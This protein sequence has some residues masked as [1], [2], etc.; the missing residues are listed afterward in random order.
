MY[1][2]PL[3]NYSSDRI[4]TPHIQ[5][6]LQRSAENGSEEPVVGQPGD[7]GEQSLVVVPEGLS[8]AV[9]QTGELLKIMETR[10]Q[11]KV[12][13]VDQSRSKEAREDRVVK[14]AAC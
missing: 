14:E 11:S 7:R 8:E 6:I 12:E 1:K 10:E 4:K 5:T 9:Q 2:V 13:T 3:P